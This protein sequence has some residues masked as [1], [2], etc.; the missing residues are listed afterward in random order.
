[1]Q[2]RPTTRRRFLVQSALASTAFAAPLYIPARVFGA[3]ER[4][5]T[6]HIG[7]GGQGSANLGGFGNT[8][9]AVCDVDKTR[10][11]AVAQKTGGKPYSD[12]RKLLEQKD[13]D[14]VVIST[15]DHWHALATIAA[16]NA[17][18]HVYV[19]KPLSLTVAEGRAMVNAARKNKV[20]VQTGSQQRSGGEFL[21]ACE[22]VRNGR[23]GKLKEVHVGIHGANHPGK[24]PADSDPPATLDYDL[25]LGPAP[26]RPYNEKRVHYNFRFW[27]DY[28]GGQMTNWGAHHLD[29]AHWG[30]GVDDAGPLEVE[31]VE[32]VFN[33]HGYHEVTEKCRVVMKYPG[34]VTLTIGQ[35]QP[36]I[37]GGTTFIGEKGR[38]HVDRGRVSCHPGD[39]FAEPLGTDALRLYASRGHKQNFIDCIKSGELPCADVEIGHRTATACHLAN[40]ACRVGEKFKWD[41]RRE[42]I[43]GSEK[44]AALLSREYR[45]PWTLDLT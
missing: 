2:L 38:I 10:L 4:I 14:A 44:A 39:I 21:K 17:G 19:E 1:M 15:P 8:I 45:K 26:M 32:A 33:P 6:G 43:V 5:V 24:L 27:W 41:A 16:C 11:E 35:G 36:G 13:I 37:A 23:I 20:I 22:Y 30:M 9:G 42:Q 12:F 40:I 34:N 31:A 7:G 3:N 29:I 25:W 28:S 18:K